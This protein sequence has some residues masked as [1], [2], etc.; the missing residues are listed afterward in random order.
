MSGMAVAVVDVV[1]MVPVWDGDMPAVGTVLVVMSL[2]D[3]VTRGLAL[4]DM[5]VVC[6][7]EVAVVRVV[8]VV[9]VRYGDVAAAASV[10]VGVVGVGSVCA[11][12]SRR[13]PRPGR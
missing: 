4:V 10:P 1:H 13:R 11:R 8:D 12:G 3:G 5:V 9:G 2:V 6:P 7:V